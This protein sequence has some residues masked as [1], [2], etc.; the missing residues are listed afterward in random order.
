MRPRPRQATA[1]KSSNLMSH[2]ARASVLGQLRVDVNVCQHTG[3][4]GVVGTDTPAVAER[5]FARRGVG[6]ESG[7][8]LHT[9]VP[10]P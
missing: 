2:T 3:P 10:L 9:E 7:G 5:L 8:A 1:G 4:V 6:M